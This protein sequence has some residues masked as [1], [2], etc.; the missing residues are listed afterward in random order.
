LTWKLT[1]A[2]KQEETAT[3]SGHEHDFRY[4]AC[5]NLWDKGEVTGVIDVWR[6]TVCHVKGIELR[7]QGLS[8]LAT[9]TGFPVLDGPDSNWVVFVCGA[10][11]QLTYDV[12]RVH[13]GDVIDHECVEKTGPIKVGSGYRLEDI[14]NKFH[15]IQSIEPYLNETMDLAI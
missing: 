15:K 2:V 10:K 5:V 9:E 8:N 14:K 6:C 12:L 3:K 7:A 1:L 13:I 4:Y 11:E